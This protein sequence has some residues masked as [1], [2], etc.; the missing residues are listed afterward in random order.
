MPK[1]WYKSHKVK[2]DS[3]LFAFY[4]IR[5]KITIMEDNIRPMAVGG[6]FYPSDNGVLNLMLQGFFTPY[7]KEK[8]YDNLA[9]IIVPHAGYVFSGEVA[10]S[11]MA[12]INPRKKYDNIILIGAS[13]QVYMDGASVNNSVDY[14]ASPFGN[15]KVNTELGSMLIHDNKCFSYN[16]QAHN[17]EHSLEVQLPLLQYWLDDMPTIVPIIIGTQSIDIIR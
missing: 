11:A 6:S 15:V 5:L 12:E 8:E 10:A 16:P 4:F 9:A 1:Y 7:E 14:Y 2:T 3:I 13:H 17:K